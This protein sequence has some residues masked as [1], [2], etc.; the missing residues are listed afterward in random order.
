MATTGPVTSSIALYAASLGESPFS[1][2]RSTFS[3]TTMAS[4]TTIPIASTRPNR[5]MLLT[6]NPR[7]SMTAN[8]PRMATG[9][10]TI[11]M[12]VA[13][14]LCRNSSTTRATRPTASNSVHT[15]SFTDSRMNG[16]VS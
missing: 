12:M 8:V 7:A 11:G 1:S 4:S 15:T 10:A 13:R 2:H 5:E 9:T 3:T 6:V 14:Q 16:V